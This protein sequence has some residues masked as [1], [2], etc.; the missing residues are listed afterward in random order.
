LCYRISHQTY[1]VAPLNDLRV[2]LQL[3]RRLISAAHAF[4]NARL[5]NAI[6]SS[7]PLSRQGL[8]E[9]LFALAFQRMVYPQIWEDPEVDLETLAITP[10]CEVV[11]IASGGCNILSYLTADPKSI[12]AVETEGQERGQLHRQI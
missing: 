10:E 6:C 8:L 9:N 4:G 3:R 7:R 12:A 2:D 5:R 1:I 11:A